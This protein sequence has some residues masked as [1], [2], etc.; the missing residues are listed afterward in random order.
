MRGTTLVG[1]LGVMLLSV[2]ASSLAEAREGAFEPRVFRTPAA[3]EVDDPDALFVDVHPEYRVRAIH[4]DPLDLSGLDVRAV[5]WFEQRLRVD[6]TFALPDVGAIFVQAD[7]LDGVLFGDNGLY[8]TTPQV[9]SG[10]GLA[11]KQPNLAGWEMGLMDPLRE[12]DPDAYGPVLRA[13]EPLRINY[14]YAEV[15][16]PFG[17]LRI[18]RQPITETGAM[19]VN[20]GRSHRNRWGASYYHQAADRILFGTKISEL[21]RMLAEGDAYV[22]DRSMERGVTLGLVYDFVVEDDLTDFADDMHMVAMQIAWRTD[23]EAFLGP[24]WHDIVTSVSLVYRWDERYGSKVFSLPI[25]AAF[26]VEHLDVFAEFSMILGES[27]EISSGLADLTGDTAS[28]QELSSYGARLTADYHLGDFTFTAQWGY[29]TGDDS[30]SAADAHT[31]MTWPRDTN[32]GL[33][34]FEHIL[35]FQSARSAAIGIQALKE[36]G[37]ESFPLSEIATEGR[38]TNVNALFPQ[39]AWEP[40]EGL[41]LQLGALFAWSASPI[42]DPVQSLLRKDGETIEDDLVNFNGGK[43]AS[44]WGTELDIALRYRYR[45]FFQAVIEAA[46]LLPGPG[47]ADEHGDAVPSW[48]LET[49]FVF[50]L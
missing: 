29:A 43:P 33:L 13:I 49:R 15:K 42:V 3:H 6:T 38:V 1:L 2:S 4:I 39:I 35:A 47:L 37:A 10:V 17:L 23:D 36:Q 32:M 16:F 22:P 5:S 9:T 50:S 11:S 41:R 27:K 46:W 28:L 48:M 8:G 24:H 26:S 40:L 25:R 21:F 20:D 14:L 34:L 19:A 7:L 44:Y 45:N 18:G 31:S 30:P 12:T